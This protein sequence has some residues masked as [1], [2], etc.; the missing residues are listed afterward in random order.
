MGVLKEVAKAAKKLVGFNSGALVF[1]MSTK[2]NRERQVRRDFENAKTEKSPFTA[3]MVE[4]NNYYNNK[5]YTEMQARE[6]QEKLGINFTPPVLPDGFIQ[7]ES[8]VDPIL[9]TFQFTGKQGLD[10]KKAKER[11]LITKYVMY[12]NGITELN[13]DNER[14]LNEL[15]NAFWKVSWDGSIQGL[16]YVGDIVIGNPDPANIFPDPNAYDMD[17]CEY[18]IYGFRAHRRLLRRTF[19]DILDSISNDGERYATEIYQNTQ[20]KA[21]ANDETLLVL[22]HWYRDDDGDPCCSIQI[23]YTEVKHIDKYWKLT[24]HSGN[25]MYPFIKYGKIPVRKS[26]WDKGEIETIKDLI[27][28]GN[29]EFIT[30][31]LNDAF[32]ANDIL[33]YEKGALAEG[34]E[35][36]NVPGGKVQVNPGKMEG[37]KRLGG[38]SENRGILEMINFIHEKIQE[39]NANYDANQG[40]EPVRVTTSS[41]IAQLN[42]KADARKLIKKAGRT[43]GFKRLAQLIDWTAL[44]FYTLDRLITIGADPAD[45]KDQQ[46]P[47]PI[48][49]NSSNHSVTNNGQPYFPKV[50]VE[51][52]AGDGIKRSKAFTLSATQELA[53]VKVTPENLQIVLSQVDMLDLPNGDII[54]QAMTDAVAKQQQMAQAQVPQ[55][56][57]PAESITFKDMP[58]SGKIQMAAQVGIQ[59]QPQDF[60]PDP[61]APQPQDN[62]H[63][64][65]LTELQMKHQ[66]LQDNFQQEITKIGIDHQ[67]QM[68]KMQQQ[69][70][71][72]LELVDAKTK[73]DALLNE[74][75]AQHSAVLTAMKPTGGANDATT[76]NQG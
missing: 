70:Q 69:H 49:F 74:Q 15:G 64:L 55:P 9:P 44:E 8:Q 17:D 38:V 16:G 30:A 42:E 41:G 26:F 68:A 22:E 32:M 2:E 36:P 46:P 20:Y 57:H 50:D 40:Q 59:L 72:N 33:L 76:N 31:I 4:M 24:R 1:D 71:Q 75:K 6:L 25:K 63:A 45:Q 58:P 39:V 37:I 28:A 47:E 14:A 10:P 21:L 53:N 65:A 27:D 43:E 35:V 73:S 23:N 18:F 3:K 19:G 29:R 12:N 7:V 60:G 62:S 66:Q 48:K 5:P 51:V 56:A 13:L 67:S 11:E 54:K 34:E 52:D 61:N